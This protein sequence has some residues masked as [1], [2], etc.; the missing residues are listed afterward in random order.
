[1]HCPVLIMH[2]TA[3]SVVSFW[4]A[5]ELFRK[6]NEPK[7]FFP[8]PGADHNDAVVASTGGAI[9]RFTELLDGK[10]PGSPAR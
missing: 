6:A 10:R 5:E 3:D 8:I 2:G 7:Q 4:H 9:A 1:V